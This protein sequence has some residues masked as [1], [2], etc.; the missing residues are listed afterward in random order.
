MEWRSRQPTRWHRQCTSVLRQ[1]LPKLELRSGSITTEKEDTYMDPILEHYWVSID[2]MLLLLKCCFP[3]TPFL[4][5]LQSGNPALGVDSG[6][7][8][9]AIGSPKFEWEPEPG[10]RVWR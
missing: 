2:A 10:S 6:Y 3:R 8:G 4:G 9:Q 7:H 5:T 1:I